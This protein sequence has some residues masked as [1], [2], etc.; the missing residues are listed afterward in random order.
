MGLN[1]ASIA[2]TANKLIDGAGQA[3]SIRRFADG[4]TAWNPTRTSTDYAT[5]AYIADYR[6]FE[7][8]GSVIL[9]T[10]RRAYTKV[11]SLTITPNSSDRFIVGSDDLAIV[12]VKS[13]N[14]A[15]S[16]VLYEIQVRP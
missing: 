5:V 8:D 11:G 15:G 10:D 4:G 14:V 7:I 16:N 3:V 12:S 6:S 2:A 1:A 9:A 13:Y